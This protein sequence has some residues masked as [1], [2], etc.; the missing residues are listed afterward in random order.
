MCGQI[1]NKDARSP[2]R[3]CWVK[4]DSADDP[5]FRGPPRTAKENEKKL[6]EA[7]VQVHCLP[8]VETIQQHLADAVDDEERR[9]RSSELQATVDRELKRALQEFSV[10]HIPADAWSLPF[11]AHQ[12]GVNSAAPP[13]MLHQFNLGLMKRAF[14]NI[15]KLIKS[16]TK[17]KAFPKAEDKKMVLPKLPLRPAEAKKPV[18]TSKEFKARQRAA[19]LIKKKKGKGGA[20]KWMRSSERLAELYRRIAAMSSRHNGAVIYASSSWSLMTLPPMC[21][22]IQAPKGICLVR[23]HERLQADRQ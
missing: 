1:L 22:S 19:A 18:K 8:A 14:K 4:K 11:G 23:E 9:V 16:M 5:L 13:D 6:R 2:C 20:D 7:E 3:M 12:G 21:R 17:A 15:L 10:C